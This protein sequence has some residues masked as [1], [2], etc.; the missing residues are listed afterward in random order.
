MNTAKA[1]VL[2]LCL[3]SVVAGSAPGE[4]A[5]VKSKAGKVRVGT[6]DS[7]SVAIAFAGSEAFN[8]WMGALKAEHDKAKAAGDYSRV[9]QLEAEG[10]ARQT[11]MHRQ[12]FSTAPW[13]TSFNRSRTDCLRSKR[14]L[15]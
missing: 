9:A 5:S 2:T 13:T 1:V 3:A 15:A 4:E 6:Y 10:V 12:G 8:I 14:R 7:R 11:L